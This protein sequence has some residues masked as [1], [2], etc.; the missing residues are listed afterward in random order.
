MSRGTGLIAGSPGGTGRPGL[1]MESYRG[2]AK[3][4]QA[5]GDGIHAQECLRKAALEAH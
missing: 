4:Y 1:V 2:M 5:L 3:A